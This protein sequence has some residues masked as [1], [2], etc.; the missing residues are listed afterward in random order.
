MDLTLLKTFVK[1]VSLG[2]IT[3]AAAALF[4]T[5]SAVSRRIKQLEDGVGTPLL[6]RNGPTLVPTDAGL[7]LLDKGRKILDLEQEFLLGLGAPAARRAISFCSTPSLGVDRLARVLESFISDHAAT[8]DLHCVFAM[9]E[10]ALAGI[11]SERFDLA[12]IEHCDEVEFSNRLIWP[13]PHDEVLFVSAPSLEIPAGENTLDMLLGRRLFLKTEQG[14]AKRFI[15]KNL[16]ALNR[17]CRDFSSVVYFDDLSFIR[18]EVL[19]GKGV[20]FASSA[21][22]ASELEAGMLRAHRVR[23]FDHVR[24]RTLIL[25]RRRFSAIHNTFLDYLFEEF[26]VSSPHDLLEGLPERQRMAANG[27]GPR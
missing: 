9:P 3:K 20:T 7:L 8:V 26:G 21:L 23:G 14:C 27:D 17:S 1:V 13:L 16:T 4:V 10:E 19:A 12:L 11:D 22:F 5:Q 25:G 15:D 6:D 24:P 18:R 2:S